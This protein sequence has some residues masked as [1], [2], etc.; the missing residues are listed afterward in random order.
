M[1]SLISRHGFQDDDTMTDQRQMICVKMRAVLASGQ[2]I[3][4]SGLL[5]EAAR[6]SEREKKF[7]GSSTSLGTIMTSLWC[8]STCSCTSWCSS[9]SFGSTHP[10]A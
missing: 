3:F 4:T 8:L 9:F 7:I 6:T 1:Q 10:C 5:V 2:V